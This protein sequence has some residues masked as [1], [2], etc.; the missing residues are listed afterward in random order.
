MRAIESVAERLGNTPSI[1][2]K[3]YVHPGVIEAYLDGTIAEALLVRTEQELSEDLH[4][5]Q[6]EEAAVVA[7]LQQRL[8]NVVPTAAKAKRRRSAKAS[9]A[10]AADMHD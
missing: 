10:V 2:R 5:L 3:C 8:Q 6:P 4:V 7:L 1:C 9:E